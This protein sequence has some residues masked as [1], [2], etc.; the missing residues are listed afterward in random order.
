MHP[1]ALGAA[2]AITMGVP[3]FK[4]YFKISLMGKYFQVWALWKP[5]VCVVPSLG[6]V[7]V[8]VKSNRKKPSKQKLHYRTMDTTT[9]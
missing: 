6:R 3:I 5:S 8:N 2:A 4:E 9:Y 7:H 1:A